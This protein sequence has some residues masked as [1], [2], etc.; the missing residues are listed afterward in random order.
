MPS[1]LFSGQERLRSLQALRFL[2]AL[3]VVFAHAVDANQAV[4]IR[5]LVEGTNLENF[6]S[7]GV[8]IFFVI[9][10]F[11]ITFTAKRAVSATA[12]WK[13]RFF[14]VA[15]IYWVLSVPMAMLSLRHSGFDPRTFAA[16]IL[17]WPVY[18]KFIE[19]YLTIGWTL[20]FEA[21][22]YFAMGLNRLGIR[23]RWLFAAY[24]AALLA[25]HLYPAPSLAFLGNPI[26]LEFLFG[27]AIACLPPSGA[28]LTALVAGLACLFGVLIFGYG[29]ISEALYIQD[30]S[31]S[32]VRVA[33][34][35]L[36]SA[37]IVYGAINLERFCRGRIWDILAK[38]GDASYATYLSHLYVMLLLRHLVKRLGV[39]FD[40]T[41]AAVV[42][43]LIAGWFVYRLV[44]TPLRHRLQK[45]HITIMPQ[46]NM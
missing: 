40:F 32:F 10:G 46:P 19:P 36:P 9:S 3:L 44:E 24:A 21:L 13:D 28:G 14:R 2:A 45:R 33:W 18:G 27:V 22:F 6:G 38:L 34:W 8:D 17:F 41:I 37:L 35:G 30:A 11:I 7:V 31:L 15:P 42:L 39:T 1:S 26:I 20:A 12:F 5:P 23:A 25:L 43:A 16:T 4:G 29:Q